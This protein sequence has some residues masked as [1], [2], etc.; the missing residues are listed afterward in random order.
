MVEKLKAY[1]DELLA[2]VEEIKN[3]DHSAEIEA[4]TAEFRASLAAAL[5]AEADRN[6]LKLNSDIDCIN[7]LIEKE[8]AA[9]VV[10]A[11]TVPDVD[12][13]SEAIE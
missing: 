1:R 13:V 3:A 12:S 11:E 2:E 8:E 7:R 6:I 10:E 9:A 4:K 5:E